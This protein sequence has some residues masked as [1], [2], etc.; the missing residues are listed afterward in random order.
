MK[1]IF[2]LIVVFATLCFMLSCAEVET[3]IKSEF[4]PV[5]LN[6]KG[7]IE[8]P[9]LT[10]VNATGFEA[11]DNVGVYVSNNGL[12]ANNG[13]V[14]DNV[15]FNYVE[16]DLIAPEGTEVFWGSEST[17]LSVYAY[18]PYAQ[19]ISNV[20][21]Y[22]FA[23]SSD[24]SEASDYYN[25]DFL[26]AS[27][28]NLAMQTTPVD[29]TFSHAL[30]QI[31]I[32]LTPDTETTSE[33]LSAADKEFLIQGVVTQGTI[34][35]ESGAAT[36]GA[37]IEDVQPMAV[38]ALNYSAVV[39]PQ[40]GNITFR[41]TMNGDIYTYSTE[42]V[43]KAGHRYHYTLKI[44]VREPQEMTLVSTSI[45]A[46]EDG[47]STEA[48]MTDL[49]AFS[50]PALKEYLLQEYSYEVS[51][52]D[53]AVG[54]S[55]GEERIDGNNDGEISIAEA[56][57]VTLIMLE[58]ND[59]ITTLNDL[60]WFPNLQI[61]RCYD[62]ALSE[63]DFLYNPKLVYVALNGCGLTTLDVSMLAS[64]ASLDCGANEISSLDVS[65]NKE[66][67]WF[68][69]HSNKIT[70]LNIS[71]NPKLKSLDCFGCQLSSLNTSK[72]LELKHLRLLSDA[73]TS[74]DL[75]KNTKLEYLDCASCSLSE[76]DLTNNVALLTLICTDN[77]LASLDISNSPSLKTL[78]CAFNSL[79]SLDLS[80][81]PVLEQV[82]CTE[83]AI[84]TIYLAEG[85]EIYSFEKDET[86]I[87][88]YK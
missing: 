44:N 39:F 25:S 30:S 42:F 73:I 72:N 46:W 59:A 3:D 55:K 28:P 48:E 17:R 66:L 6:L 1:K 77:L 82:D 53:T 49:V 86:A 81:N 11:N 12:L 60:R 83:N 88:E 75:S 78:Y 36:A 67:A 29:L 65:H 10:R 14:L 47:D 40:C 35:L 19:E 23:V 13:N 31:T 57:K 61:L 84:E 7:H 54:Y 69:C 51:V 16:G 70:N 34:N 21:A 37:T 58:G 71:N 5:V 24:Q 74:L 4:S 87:V 15:A 64:L 38:D 2:S 45:N 76:L 8:K 20:V 68:Q 80:N 50:S 56:E 9:Q 62:M 85:Q 22:P 41:L 27:A 43:Y 18:Y 52:T 63:V 79:T 32:T 26:T 33:E